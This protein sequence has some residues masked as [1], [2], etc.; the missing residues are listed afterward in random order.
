M[1]GISVI[2]MAREIKHSFQTA[3][4]GGGDSANG[5]RARAVSSS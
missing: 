4:A 1:V 2:S 5:G 3:P